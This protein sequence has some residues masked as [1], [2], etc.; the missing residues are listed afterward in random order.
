MAG[1]QGLED[2]LKRGSRYG[3]RTGEVV[4]R[5][6][7]L[8]IHHTGGRRGR[9]RPLQRHPGPGLQKPC[10]RRPGRVRSNSRSEGSS[11]SQRQE[12]LAAPSRSLPPGPGRGPGCSTRRPTRK[13]SSL[14]VRTFDDFPLTPAIRDAIARVGYT[15]PTPIQARAIGPILEGRDVIGCAQTGTGKTAAFAIPTVERLGGAAARKFGSAGPRALVL[16]PTREL[17]V[18]IAETFDM[19]GRAEGVQTI[20][21]IGGESM[22]PQL[23]QLQRRPDVIV[24]TP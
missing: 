5:R 17:A 23:A 3:S 16:A 19:L 21:L 12:G 11:G 9:F 2:P 13:D 8:W 15:T 18:Q 1:A 7:G 20:V 6:E 24:A 14:M 22:G 4:Q 10:R